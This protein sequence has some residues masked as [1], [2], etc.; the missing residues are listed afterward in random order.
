MKR[1][2]SI[3]RVNYPSQ[4]IFIYF[5]IQISDHAIRDRSFNILTSVYHHSR[6][7]ARARAQQE[8]LVS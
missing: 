3:Y 4:I 5:A 7:R 8:D 6:A 1:R 2:C